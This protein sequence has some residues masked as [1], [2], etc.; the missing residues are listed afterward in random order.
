[1]LHIRLPDVFCKN[2]GHFDFSTVPDLSC[3][4]F[5]KR[6]REN[7]ETISIV[8]PQL[9]IICLYFGC[10]ITFDVCVM[11]KSYKGLR[12]QQQIN[13]TERTVVK[14]FTTRLITICKFGVR[15]FW[16]CD[17]LFIFKIPASGTDFQNTGLSLASAKLAVKYQPGRWNTC[18]LA[19]LVTDLQCFTHSSIQIRISIPLVL[20][21]IIFPNRKC[22]LQLMLHVRLW[23][24]PELEYL[25]NIL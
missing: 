6:H 21:T 8:K 3:V 11:Q 24:R 13:F 2:T 15:S 18:H 16:N 14:R 25:I 1:M 12:Q 10:L 5:R 23:I 22:L 19:T 9:I 17:K 20:S 7:R 4:V